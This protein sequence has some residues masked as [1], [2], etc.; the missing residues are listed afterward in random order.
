MSA[1]DKIPEDSRAATEPAAAAS[2]EQQQA[3]I[4]DLQ[5]RLHAERTR[6]NE[7]LRQFTYAISH[8][9]REPLRMVAS[10]AQLLNRRYE[11]RLDEDG[12]EFLGIIADAVQRMEKLLA[13]LVTYS[14]QFHALQEPARAV[15]S[16]AAFESALLAIEEEVRESGA[17]ITHDPLPTIPFDFQRMTQLFRQLVGNSIKFRG[18]DTPRIHVAAQSSGEEVTFSICDNGLGIDPRYHEQIFAVF[19]R[20]NGKQYPGTG[21]GLAICKRI[22]EQQGGRIWVES[23]SGKGATFYFTLPL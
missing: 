21:I 14:H 15:D 3:T 18:P 5:A 7:E 12:R 22:V 9:L 6:H 13:D 2:A 11:D 19:R 23:E 20:L 17:Q 8:D 10:Y 4:E 16:E 1:Q